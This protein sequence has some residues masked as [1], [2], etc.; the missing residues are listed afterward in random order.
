MLLGIDRFR[1]SL[2]AR[3]ENYSPWRYK[4][5]KRLPEIGCQIPRRALAELAPSLPGVAVIIRARQN[6]SGL[7]AND[8]DYRLEP[9]RRK[10]QTFAGILAASAKPGLW[11]MTVLGANSRSIARRGT[12]IFDPIRTFEDPREILGQAPLRPV[13]W[14]AART[15]RLAAEP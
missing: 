3:I 10:R 9:Q 2:A 7:L 11:G 12:V 8:P 14:T 6:I 15:E 4:R 13:S 5:P 1:Y